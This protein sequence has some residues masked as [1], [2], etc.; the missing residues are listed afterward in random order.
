MP[1]QNEPQIETSWVWPVRATIPTEMPRWEGVVG[2]VERAAELE[3]EAYLGLHAPRMLLSTT[4]LYGRLS[5][6][7]WMFAL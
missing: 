1:S 4:T 2:R 7:H 6:F 3:V 5:L